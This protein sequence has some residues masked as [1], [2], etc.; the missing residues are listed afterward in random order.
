[1][2]V[3][4]LLLFLIYAFAVIALAVSVYALWT[5]EEIK[6]ELKK[7]NSIKPKSSYA[8]KPQIQVPRKKGHWD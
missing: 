4:L 7:K 2:Y 1:M 6:Q 8:I 5:L 3:D